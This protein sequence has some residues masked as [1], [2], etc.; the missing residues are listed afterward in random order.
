M[1]KIEPDKTWLPLGATAAVIIS[2]AV[3]AWRVSA[4]FAE[5][6]TEIR[7]TSADRWTGADMQEF[8]YQLRD[9]NRERNLTVPN[10]RQVR[11][12]RLSTEASLK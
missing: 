12:D 10:P 1:I 11:A 7:A 3:G 5:L 4:A 6:K 9:G 2:I 8:A